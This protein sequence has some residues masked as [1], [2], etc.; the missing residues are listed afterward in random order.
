MSEDDIK[1]LILEALH[2]NGDGINNKIK[3]FNWHDFMRLVAIDCESF[4]T[5]DSHSGM[6][7]TSV[8]F[9][10]RHIGGVYR[11]NSVF[12]VS[13]YA[14]YVKNLCNGLNFL[15]FGK[16]AIGVHV[17][18]K[19]SCVTISE[20]GSN[21]TSYPLKDVISNDNIVS[22]VMF[23]KWQVDYL[24]MTPFCDVFHILSSSD[25]LDIHTY[26]LMRL[27]YPTPEMSTFDAMTGLYTMYV[28]HSEW[29]NSYEDISQLYVSA[30]VDFNCL[31]D[32]HG[33]K[34]YGDILL[35]LPYIHRQNMLQ[36]IESQKTRDFIALNSF[37]AHMQ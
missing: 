13:H 36:Y 9:G 19:E 35:E 29:V 23:T 25:L 24:S 3:A 21:I 4:R 32:G 34:M 14:D 2:V 6:L 31:L 15:T 18:V 16:P 12:N 33:L 22:D 11:Y 5:G 28:R 26:L 20:F 17:V 1:V 30:G 27:N 37:L 8:N 7:I 10:E